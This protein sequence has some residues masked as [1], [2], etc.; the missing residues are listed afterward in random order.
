MLVLM[1]EDCLSL[2]GNYDLK[3][4]HEYYNL[5]RNPKG[6]TVVQRTDNCRGK[7]QMRGGVTPSH[8]INMKTTMQRT[9]GGI[10]KQ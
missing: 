10:T 2:C 9:K 6:R 3:A 1:I 8:S 5:I 7:K 4:A